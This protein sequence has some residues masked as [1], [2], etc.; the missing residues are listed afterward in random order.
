[1]S[2]RKL[3]Q[4]FPES[5]P[6]DAMIGPNLMNIYTKNGGFKG[7]VPYNIDQFEMNDVMKHIYINIV[8][9]EKTIEPVY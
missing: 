3:S 9:L 8:R 4:I 7:S 2:W 5:G 6:N 1:M